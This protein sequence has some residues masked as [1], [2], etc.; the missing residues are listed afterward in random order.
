MMQPEVMLLPSVYLILPLG[1]LFMTV[2]GNDN[3]SQKMPFPPKAMPS[4]MGAGGD[5]SPTLTNGVA[6]S[7]RPESYTLEKDFRKSVCSQIDREL[8]LI[9]TLDGSVTEGKETDSMLKN[10][11]VSPKKGEKAV[12]SDMV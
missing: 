10:K 1:S 3:E 5:R 4:P 6:P 8:N 2:N 9:D 11:A 12:V 7:S